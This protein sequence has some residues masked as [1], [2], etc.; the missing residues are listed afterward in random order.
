M[1]RARQK[2]LELDNKHNRSKERSK[3]H[4]ESSK[5]SSS[6]RSEYEKGNQVA[7]CSSHNPDHSDCYS[8]EDQRGLQDEEIEQ[9]LRSRLDFLIIFYSVAEKELL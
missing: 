7:S 1:W 5:N 9:F 8:D 3:H 6:H 2:E 4:G